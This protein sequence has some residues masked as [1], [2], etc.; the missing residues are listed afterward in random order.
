M[1]MIETPY[2]GQGRGFLDLKWNQ[3]QQRIW[4]IVALGT[5]YLEVTDLSVDGPLEFKPAD[6]TVLS[7]YPNPFNEAM[8]IRYDLL[9]PQKVELKVYDVQG[10][11]VRTLVD[12]V[13]LAGKH[14]I[15]ASMGEMASGVYFVRLTTA[16]KEK[17]EKI[18]LLK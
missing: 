18:V 4:A 8:R 10:R 17:T 7:V 12:E 16:Q 13:Q 14:E 1:P 3:A 11:L 2:P 9:R 6:Y 15:S 5:C